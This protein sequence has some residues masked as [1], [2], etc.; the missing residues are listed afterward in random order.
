MKSKHLLLCLFITP[1]LHAAELTVSDGAEIDW[2]GYS[3]SLS[4]DTGLI[5]AV[6]DDDKGDDSGSAYVFR[7]LDTTTG[8]INENVKLIASDSTVYDYFGQSVSL[9]GNIGLVGAIFGDGN[10][11]DSGSAYIFR[12][13][14]TASGTV[15][16]SVKLI[17]SDGAEDD[18]FGASV[19][20]SGTTGLVGAYGD[21]D[22]GDDSGSA[23]VFRDLDTA[24]GTVNESVKLT[25]SDGAASDYFG[26][27]VSLSGTIGLIGANED[28]DKG[29]NSGSAY[30]FRDLDTASGTVTQNVKLIAS[31]GAAGDWFGTSV[32]LS[33]TIGLVGAYGDDDNGANSGSAYVF[34]DLD[35]ASGTVTQNV[36]LTASDGKAV[37]YFGYSVSLSGTTGLIGAMLGEGNV[38]ASGSAYIFLDLDTASGSITESVKLTASD[39]AIYDCFGSSVSLDGDNFLIG[40]YG[41]D[42]GLGKTYSGSVSSITTLD[43]GSAS[44][45]ISGISF[46]SRTDWIIGKTTANNTVTLS[47][48]DTANVTTTL[49]GVYIGKEAGSDANLLDIAGI[50]AA[51]EVH[52]GDVTGGNF[53]NI[54][55]LQNTANI[56]AVATILLGTLSFLEIE[57]DYTGIGGLLAYLGDTDLQVWDGTALQTVDSSNYANL[58]SA[59]YD[60]TSGF[61]TISVIPEPSALLLGALG[62]LILLRRRKWS[63]SL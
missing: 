46:E 49:T 14:D 11:T 41:K 58:I 29:T 25:A 40:A 52:I 42:S 44:R 7:D 15:N 27:S 39:G 9:S 31:D 26:T 1:V 37:D 22:K 8:T 63:R 57:G 23:Y 5:G 36:K 51:N 18:Y 20:L 13:L 19:S 32:S 54:L 33:G 17:A 12:N 61:T 50:L 56:D 53:G 4:G 59:S 34:R 45:T 55:R 30:V 28:D 43:E 47:A 16:E 38:T 21:D 10:A 62:S 2:F 48:G 6:Y 24:T 60:G 3:A 35:T